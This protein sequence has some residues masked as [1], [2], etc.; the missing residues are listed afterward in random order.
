MFMIPYIDN[1]AI[2]TPDSRIAAW[3]PIWKRNRD[4]IEGER[5]VKPAGRTYLPAPPAPKGDEKD[6]V[7]KNTVA[8]TPFFPGAARTHE[9]LMGLIFHKPANIE[10]GGVPDILETITQDGYSI[11]HLAEDVVSE[12]MITNFVGLVCDYPVSEKRLDARQAQLQG[13]RPFIGLYQAESILGIE[14]GVINNRQRVT[15]VR[16]VEDDVTIRELRLDDGVYSV[17]IW[18]ANAGTWAIS[19]TITPRKGNETLDE[20]PFSLVTSNRKYLPAKAKLSDVVNVNLA[21][22]SASRNLKIAE[23]W[24]GN[25]TPYLF[26]TKVNSMA[27]GP[28]NY[29]TAETNGSE[30]KVGMLEPTGGALP[31]LRESVAV[32][33]NDMAKVGSRVLAAEKAAVEAG[34]TLAIKTASENAVVAGTARLSCHWLNDQL[35]WV[36]YWLGLEEGSISYTLNTD[37]QAA[38]LTPDE[39][40][41]LV[42]E[43]KA[44][45]YS[46]DTLIDQMIEGGALP[47]SFDRELD[48]EKL[49]EEI[50]D[51]P[52][53]D[54]IIPMTTETNATVPPPADQGTTPLA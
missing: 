7:Y 54:S 3:H 16:L 40:K 27:L 43:W 9:G 33:A 50:A 46:K 17:N 38:K 1:S 34:E 25:P 41:Q 14:T 4:V 30:I 35:D 12:L 53:V 15:R 42:E 10:D 24:A 13:V 6:E 5:M 26:G 48:Q 51:R 37:Y 31:G 49:G 47:E 44:N 20:I 19:Q 22:Y 36:A 29:L 21:H 11:D 45:V 2:N 18:K 8:L 52:P 28:G 32:L 39:R 23:F